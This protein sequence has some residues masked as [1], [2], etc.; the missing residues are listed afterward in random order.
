MK[1]TLTLLIGL[2][3]GCAIGAAGRDLVAT[4]R[5][6]NVAVPIYQYRVLNLGWS[7]AQGAEGQLNALGQ[8]GWRVVAES[9]AYVTFERTYMVYPRQPPPAPRAH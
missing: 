7:S 2:L 8:Q 6:Q 9:G 3:L 5:A 1:R 4:A